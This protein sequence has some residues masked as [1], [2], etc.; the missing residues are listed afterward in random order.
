MSVSVLSLLLYLRM[1]VGSSEVKE[2]RVNNGAEFLSPMKLKRVVLKKTD[3][4]S[5]HIYCILQCLI[6]HRTKKVSDNTDT[7]KVRSI[8]GYLKW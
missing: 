6:K 7:L 5:K 4:N 8:S 3:T 2:G 1:V